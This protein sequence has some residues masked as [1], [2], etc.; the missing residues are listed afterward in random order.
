MFCTLRYHPA[1]FEI[2]FKTCEEKQKGQISLDRGWDCNNLNSE[3]RVAN[4]MNFF[5]RVSRQ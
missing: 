2:K 3:F 1:K 4:E 5:W